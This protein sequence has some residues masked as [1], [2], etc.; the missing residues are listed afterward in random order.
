MSWRR[1]RDMKLAPVVGLR[2]VFKAEHARMMPRK[3]VVAVHQPP[4][5]VGRPGL[6]RRQRLHLA[7]RW[8]RFR[9]KRC[10]R[11]FDAVGAR[12]P[13]DTQPGGLATVALGRKA[14][15]T[16]DEAHEDHSVDRE[17]AQL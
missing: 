12:K 13:A 7:C 2:R 6:T 17:R 1:T 15:G 16:N 5:R 14:M 10:H 8:Q 11:R 4:G 3:P 9:C